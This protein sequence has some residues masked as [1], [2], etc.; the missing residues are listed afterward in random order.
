MEGASS[1][2]GIR[3]SIHCITTGFGPNHQLTAQCSIG[4]G[5]RADTGRFGPVNG[6]TKETD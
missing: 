3:L 5:R 6:I 4:A 1:V 2:Q